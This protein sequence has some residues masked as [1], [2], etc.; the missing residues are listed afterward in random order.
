ME[1]ASKPGSGKWSLLQKMVVKTVM[2][3]GVRKE[4]ATFKS[5]LWTV[6]Y[7]TGSLT[8]MEHAVSP[9]EVGKNHGSEQFS[10]RPPMV[11]QI[12]TPTEH[13]ID[14]ATLKS[15]LLTVFCLTGSVTQ[16]ESAVKIV[17][18]EWSHG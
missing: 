14:P 6:F 3:I 17:E 5:V 13:K 1:E 10:K 8:P 12:V 9:A 11:E 7:L 15:V 16:K 2:K 4:I 18:V